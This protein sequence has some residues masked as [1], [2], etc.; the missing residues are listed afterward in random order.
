VKD[1]CRNCSS[2]L[3]SQSLGNGVEEDLLNAICSKLALRN[4]AFNQASGS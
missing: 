2:P 1:S 3:C 4:W